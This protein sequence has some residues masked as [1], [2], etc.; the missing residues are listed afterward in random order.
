MVSAAP[1]GRPPATRGRL[2]LGLT[3]VG[4]VIGTAL[5][6]P[7]LTSVDPS[8]Q[9]LLMSLAGP[10]LTH[11]LGTDPLGRDMLA[12]LLHGAPR[13]L[14]IAV[15]CVGLAASVGIGLGIVAA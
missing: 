6:G 3:F 8:A 13:S 9:N 2:I 12:R 4:V 7:Y 5:L 11:P 14:G 15:L 10:S 1:P